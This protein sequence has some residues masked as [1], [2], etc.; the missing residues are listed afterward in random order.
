[1]P[2]LGGFEVTRL[3]ATRVQA[4]PKILIL[5]HLDQQEYVSQARECGAD[6]FVTKVSVASELPTAIRRV[7]KGES[8]FAPLETP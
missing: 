1:M 3:V 4:H 8:L 7:F 5:T 6:G 2:N